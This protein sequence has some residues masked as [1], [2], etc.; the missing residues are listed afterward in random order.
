MRISDERMPQP[1]VKNAFR[2][3]HLL[4]TQSFPQRGPLEIGLADD[5]LATIARALIKRCVA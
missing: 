3:T 2:F 1:T 4:S 5:K